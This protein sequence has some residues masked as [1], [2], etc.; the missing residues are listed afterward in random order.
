[1]KKIKYLPQALTETRK[2]KTDYA[3][4]PKIRTINSSEV[5]LFQQ[6]KEMWGE[7][8]KEGKPWICLYQWQKAPPTL[9]KGCKKK[10][11]HNLG[12]I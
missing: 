4:N 3:N 9:P 5:R 7:K 2:R 10:T 6:E 1:L 12:R 8:Q 11:E